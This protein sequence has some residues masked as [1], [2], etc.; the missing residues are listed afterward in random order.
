MKLASWRGI[1]S[2]TTAGEADVDGSATGE[3]SVQEEVEGARQVSLAYRIYARDVAA[4][5]GQRVG[6]SNW[7]GCNNGALGL[8]ALGMNDPPKRAITAWSTDTKRRVRIRLWFLGVALM[9][10]IKSM[11]VS[12]GAI[13][14]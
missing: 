11:R 14:R 4:L 6:G 3:R 8:S 1:G 12:G 5:K 2:D 9:L 13:G 7:P 10:H